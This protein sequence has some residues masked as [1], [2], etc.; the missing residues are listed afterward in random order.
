MLHFITPLGC[1][2]KLY[3]SVLWERLITTKCFGLQSFFFVPKLLWEG[4]VGELGG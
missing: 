2:C 3:R 1:A 4:A